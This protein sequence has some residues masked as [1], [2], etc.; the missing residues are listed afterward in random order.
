VAS[1][2]SPGHSRGRLWRPETSGVARRSHQGHSGRQMVVA[3]PADGG[4]WVRRRRAFAN[5]RSRRSHS[6]RPETSLRSGSR[7]VSNPGATVRVLSASDAPTRRPAGSTVG[8][9][10]P[11][12]GEARRVTWPGARPT[13]ASTD[14]R[15]RT[16]VP[17]ACSTPAVCRGKAT[18]VAP[19][20]WTALAITAVPVD[21]R[22]PSMAGDRAGAPVD[23]HALPTSR[24]TLHPLRARDV[25][26]GGENEKS[27][28]ASRY[29]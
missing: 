28:A 10:R 4:G 22:G 11:R 2:V 21:V 13:L 6:S 7:C 14:Q 27:E 15:W 16:A 24:P 12:S 25:A 9:S 8:S 17:T 20:L 5:G 1:P 26:V 23:E 18:A 29:R 19:L 3:G